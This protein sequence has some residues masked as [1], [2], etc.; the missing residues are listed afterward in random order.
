MATTKT[1]VERIPTQE[2]RKLKYINAKDGTGMIADDL[3]L[4]PYAQAL[5]D[6]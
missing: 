6:R 3:Y 2:E 1:K 4:E 5:K